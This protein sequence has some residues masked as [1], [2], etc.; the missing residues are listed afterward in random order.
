MMITFKDKQY[1]KQK[2]CSLF[3]QDPFILKCIFV[4]KFPE[5]SDQLSITTCFLFTFLYLF[6]FYKFTDVLNL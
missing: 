1:P 3:L 5:Q 6:T 2:T 4:Q